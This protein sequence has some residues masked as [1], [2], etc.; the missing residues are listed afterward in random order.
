MSRQ[1]G[2]I[3]ILGST[4]TIGLA[5][6]DIVRR[7]PEKFSVVALAANQNISLLEEQISE[8]SPRIVAV[9]DASAGEK[10]KRTLNRSDLEVVTGQGA[11]EEAAS[12]PDVHTALVAV[13][14]YAALKPLLQA[15][16]SG[17]H[18]ALANKESVIAAGDLVNQKLKTSSS[19]LIPVDSEHNSIY[20]LLPGASSE[21]IRSITITASGGPFWNFSVEEMR[22]VTPEQAVKHPNWNMG[23]K[24]SVDSAT[25]MNKGLEVLEAVNLFGL[26][27]DRIDVL[28]HPGS[29]LH[30]LVDYQD[31]SQTAVL[32]QSDMRI[33]I[34]HALSKLAT[35][36]PKSTP[37][38]RIRESGG[39]R[40]NLGEISKLEFFAP[41]D[42]RFPALE[43]CRRASREAGLS[44]CILNAANE[45]A[46]ERFLS[47]EIRFTEIVD[48]V[49]IVLDQL[50]ISTPGSDSIPGIA[51]V[52]NAD[53][54]AREAAA[55][56]RI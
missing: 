56:I 27:E 49:R 41:D 50:A 25:M 22:D 26:P 19:S 47:G 32:F 34:A 10:L 36:E 11:V 15:I 53:A 35:K 16:D 12:F 21:E 8:F 42:S 48:I 33:P 7:N 13:T 1:P 2:N 51:E 39:A 29:I 40:L 3:A 54:S 31:G 37:G 52:E 43:L 23:A 44:P 55:S 24:I 6:L 4:G 5:G 38:L 28:V 20:Q 18:I 9:S 17:V 14:G 30:G 45:V 46:V